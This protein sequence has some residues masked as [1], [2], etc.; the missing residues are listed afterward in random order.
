[1]RKILTS[2]GCALMLSAGAWAADT[3]PWSNDFSNYSNSITGW[4]GVKVVSGSRG[5]TVSSGQLYIQQAATTTRNDIYEFFTGDGFEFQ[6]GVGY[7]FE[8]TVRTNNTSATAVNNFK[9]LVYKH[10]SAA[11]PDYNAPHIEVI[12]GSQAPYEA[13]KYTGFFE[14]EEDGVYDL[15]LYAYANY[16]SRALYFDDFVLSFGSMD[17]PVEPQV[18][19]FPN[20]SGILKADVKVTAPTKSIRGDNLASMTKLEIMRDGGVIK[21]VSDPTP[22]QVVTVTDYVAQPGNHT[23]SAM[24]YN[25]YGPGSNKDV[26]IAIGGVPEPQTWDGTNYVPYWAKY[27]PEGK[28]RI[29]WPAQPNDSTLTYKVQTMSGREIT[30]EVGTFTRVTHQPA[31]D[32]DRQVKMYYI[33][34]E[35]FDLGTEPIGW[36]YKVSSI[37]DA[38]VETHRG[39]TNYISLNNQVPYLPTMTSATSILSFTSDSDYSY[40]WQH[41]TGS[42][43]H[44]AGSLQRPYSYKTDPDYF[45]QNWLIS[46][47]LM[48]SKDKFY[49]VKLTGSADSNTVTY[50]IKAG[51][52]SYRE[53]LDILV[54]ED[55][56]TVQSNVDM[57][58]TQTDEMFL[59]VPEDGMYFVGLVPS[60]PKAVYSSNIRLRRFDIIEV[61]P[62]LPDAPTDVKVAYSATGGSSGSI[63]FKVPTKAINGDDVT[64]LTKVEVL[65]DGEA[66]TTITEGVIPGA[67]LSFPVTV[68][69]GQQNIY[70]IRV[71]NAAGQG[72]S[73]SA[74]V[75]VL[76]T[77]YLNEFSNKNDLNGFTQINNLNNGQEFHLQNN[78][79]RLFYNELGYDHWL[80]M[81][82]ITL[83][84]GQYYQFN[85]N[86]KSNGDEAGEAVVV[87][88]KAPSPEALTDTITPTFVINTEANIFNGLHEEWISV[89]ESGQYFI[90]FHITKPEGRHTKEIYIDN[91]SI[92]TGVS[93]TTPDK[94]KLEVTPDPAGE[95]TATLSYTVPTKALNGTNLNANS[96]QS[97]YFYINGE[98]TGGVQEDGTLNPTTR[99]F[100][101]YPGQTVSIKV[102]VDEELPYIFS[103]RAGYS[104]RLTYKDAFVGINIPAYP[105]PSSVVLTETRPYGHIVMTWDAVTTDYEGYPMN[106]DNVTYEVS[107]L[108]QSIYN[109][110]SFVEVPVLTGITGTT[111]EFDAISA[112]APQTMK[113]YV[114]RAR[115]TKGQGSSGVLTDYINV[116]KPY[117]MPYRESFV[118]EN[119]QAGSTTAV[120]SENF[121]GL[122]NWGIMT[123]GLQA[124]VTSGDGDGAYLAMEAVFLESRSRFYTGKV[125]LGS[126]ESPAMTFMVHNPSE[127]GAEAPNLIEVLVYSYTDGKWTSLGEP[128]SVSE[129]TGDRVGWSKVT[130]DLSAFADNV[131]I[132]AID[133]I[134]MRHTFTSLDNIRIWE[135]PA[136][137]LTLASHNMPVSA[138]PGVP[139]KIDLVIDNNGRAASAPETIEMYIDGALAKS[140]GGFEIPAGN[141]ATMTMNYTFPV[142]DLADSHDIEFKVNYAADSDVTDNALSTTISTFNSHLPAVENL[143]ATA[144]DHRNVTLSWDAPALDEDEVVTETFEDWNEGNATQNG[145]TSY[146]GDKRN[147]LGFND[148]NG[149]AIVIPGLTAFE[150]AAFAVIDN[151]NGPLPASNFPAKSGSKFLMSICP[152]GTVGSADDWMISPL[153]SGNA[154]TVKLH[155]LNYNN[156]RSGIEILYSEGGMTIN[157]FKSLAVGPIS[158]SDWTEVS[159]DLPEGA[160]RFAIRNISFC[161]DSFLL[162]IDDVTFEPSRGEDVALLGYNI[163]SENDV[164]ARP[165]ENTFT[166]D[167]PLEE[168]TY[169]FGVSARYANGE[170]NVVPVELTVIDNG[171]AQISVAEGVHVFSGNGCIHVTGAEGETVAVYDVAGR[172]VANGNVPANGCITAAP[173]VYVVVIGN[174]SFNVLVK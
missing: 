39:Y 121:E 42:G 93:G 29:E 56:S 88:G 130:Y 108:Q 103:A 6:Q 45:Y 35:A 47:G 37:T 169:V 24:A 2:L 123:D 116:G 72:E 79:A 100:N 102:K 165:A 118:K 99:T 30:G 64:G 119:G 150:P 59:S 20:E 149:G 58:V 16:D 173:G 133:A 139:V 77:P 140:M 27:T 55:H 41:N 161:E 10:S 53:A 4:K 172:L 54:T 48:L 160:K 107:Y 83:T 166:F 159:V 17:A 70:A 89:E 132:C 67:E 1:M 75:F 23:Y 57:N 94:G 12:S 40:G 171:V 34:D 33:M 154:Q 60:Y 85:Y 22:G 151:E 13:Q 129:L 157:D 124:G 84:S 7:K 163:Y 66:F 112:D 73:A 105:D 44:F 97:V 114:L 170:S 81:P 174:E 3:V 5:F 135:S 51:K 63:S 128:K 62:S 101:A 11:S 65:K 82:P 50:T 78:Q 147:I 104:G 18:E 117:R 106:P 69:A 109:P 125:N 111:C 98:Q 31:Q 14:V 9:I 152:T 46:P 110:D 90:G 28:I 156:Y 122:S 138:A 76:S 134:C 96:T 131:V 74:T 137:D 120:F 145:W 91:L 92:A 21:E 80:I 127:T 61:D 38:G 25:Q 153:L 32:Q 167:E 87:M 71:F 162:M 144:D 26:V 148:G 126:G 49:R 8:M 141:S 142:V 113:R 158:V 115:N 15:C 168:G 143:T 164:L 86:L 68:T 155:A 146:D 136:H 43:G 95:L 19:V 36:Q 52:G